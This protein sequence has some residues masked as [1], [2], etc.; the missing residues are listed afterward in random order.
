[1]KYRSV[2]FEVDLLAVDR[3]R[4]QERFRDE[5]AAGLW[6][7]K[8]RRSRIEIDVIVVV[9]CGLQ[10]LAHS[11][12]GF[13]DGS[14]EAGPPR[15]HSSGRRYLTTARVRSTFHI[16]RV[17]NVTASSFDE[18]DRYAAQCSSGAVRICQV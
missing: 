3:W 13:A 9:H 1:M 11:L 2:N 10:T 17:V 18:T 5:G 4:W 7:D 14:T 6:R 12:A 15:S 8:T 16:L